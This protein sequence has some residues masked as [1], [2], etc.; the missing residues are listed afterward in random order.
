MVSRDEAAPGGGEGV[1]EPAATTRTL[2]VGRVREIAGL[3]AALDDAIAGHGRLVL[4]SGEPGVGKTRLVEELARRAVERGVHTAWGRCW[5]QEGAPDLWPWLQV[6]RTFLRAVDDR[7]LREIVGPHGSEL[8]ALVAPLRQRAGGVALDAGSPAARFRL[9]NAIAHFLDAYSERGPLLLAL[10]D[11][12]RADPASLLL[13]QFFTQE[14]RQRRILLLATYREPGAPPT[15]ELTQAVVESLREPGSERLL[16]VGFGAAEVAA[17]LSHVLGR[18][19][20]PAFAEELRQRTGGNA[21]FVAECARHLA[22]GL[23]QSAAEVPIP[24]E[25]R[26]RIEQRLAPLSPEDRDVLGQAAALGLEFRQQELGA[27]LTEA[28]RSSPSATLAAAEGLG[29]IARGPGEGVYHFVHGMLRECLVASRR[30]LPASRAAQGPV[31]P[32]PQPAATRPQ[33]LFRREGEYWTVGFAGRT[34]RVR[35]AKGLTYVALLLRHPRKP[36]HVSELVSLGGGG[37]DVSAATESSTG[38]VGESRLGLGDAGEV[39]DSQAKAQYRRRLDELRLELEQARSFNDAGRIE[40]AQREIEFLTQELAAAVGLGGRDR[41]VGSAVERARV[42]VT[43]SIGRAVERIAEVH[44]E[45]AAHLS[46]TIRTG[47]FCSYLPDS[48]VTGTWDL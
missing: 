11:L 35:D 1:V 3:T 48:S 15:R 31:A 26:E 39:L 42:N 23:P 8:T 17:L 44:P 12:H 18:E 32:P 25:V 36:L 16:L 13:L 5:E 19:I 29:L 37:A 45:L 27:H 30:D 43:R 14:L 24:V 28:G 7:T 6:V 21:A 41:R 10:E 20:P 4:L 47:T 46:E 40:R 22:G 34:C 38:A 33:S 9:F 2:I